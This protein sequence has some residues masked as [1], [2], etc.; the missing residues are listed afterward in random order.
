MSCVL[1]MENK[2]ESL[3]STMSTQLDLYNKEYYFYDVVSKYVPIKYPKTY[4]LIK[5][6]KFNNIGVLLENLNTKDYVINLNLNEENV[7]TSLTVIDSLVTLHSAFWN[8]N[9]DRHFK[10]L[11]KNNN[12]LFDWCEFVNSKWCV[13]KNKWMNMLTQEQ[14]DVAE[15][16]VENYKTIQYQLSDKNLTFC[17]GDVKSPNIFYKILDGNKYE[18]CFIDWQ[19]ISYGKG[20][21]D[22][23]FFMIES[24][25]IVKMNKYKKLFKEYYYVKLLERGVDYNKADYD[26]DFKN[27]SYYFPFFVAIWFGTL[28][29]DDLIDKQFP[30]HF[31][32]K[33]FNFY[34]LDH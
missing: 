1:K 2:N 21:Q 17:H 10:E 16:I 33:L 4:G 19:Y 24:F 3:L 26:L 31:I 12:G 13:F 18:P 29:E 15:Y 34:I 20:V 14:M 23:V 30:L 6:D 11:K 28:S 7:E 25:D 27:A 8:K 9:I 5:D 22:L 32:K